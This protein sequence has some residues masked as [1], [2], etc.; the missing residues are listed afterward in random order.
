MQTG[1]VRTKKKTL[2]KTKKQTT[3]QILKEQHTNI[4]ERQD[5]IQ[6]LSTPYIQ[7]PADQPYTMKLMT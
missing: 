6:T 1:E 5:I 2:T 3:S 4:N 7:I